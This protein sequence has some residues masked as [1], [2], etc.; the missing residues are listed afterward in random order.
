MYGCQPCLL[1]PNPVLEFICSEANKLTNQ[2]IYTA[3]QLY[4]KTR[5]FVSKYRLNYECKPSGHYKAL[6]S[7]AAQQVLGAVHESFESYRKLLAAF[8]N[9]EI[10]TKPR[11]PNYRKK[12]GLSA[13]SYPKQAL[14][15]VNKDRVRVPLGKSV[16]AWFGIDSFTIPMPSNLGFEDIREWRIVPR[17]GCFYGE[18]VYRLQK[19]KLAVDQNKVLGIDP[20]LDNWLT[21]VSNQ[22]TSLI[23]DGRQVKSINCWYN[24]QIARIKE[25]KPQGFWSKRLASIT[26]KRNRRIR[27]AVNKA[28]RI[29]INHCLDC[30]IG[31]VVFGWNQGQRQAINL[32]KKNNQKFVQIPTARLKDR[33]AQ[34]CE[35]YG[36]Q[37]VETEESYTSQSSFLDNDFLPTIGE[38]PNSWKSSGKRTHR[39][40]FR[41]SQNHHINADANG[42]AN[43][44]KK[45]SAKLGFNLSGVSMGSLTAPQRIKLWSAKKTRSNAVLTRCVSAAA[46]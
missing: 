9:G 11:V 30:Q 18:F 24:K 46:R 44:L 42:A 17:N 19:Q 5:R 38:K 3:R 28:A 2:G 41:T 26:E 10:P 25:D 14:K 45:V 32:G 27:D 22:G 23:V 33:I 7:Q 16:K 34:L 15:L 21:C 6:Y 29:V 37:F 13:L 1:N 36:M 35:L 20:G 40:L 43:I 39:G 8:K 31:T 12:G 4:F